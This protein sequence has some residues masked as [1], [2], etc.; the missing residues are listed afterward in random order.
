MSKYVSREVL[1]QMYKLY[2]R[3]YVDYGDLICHKDDP[4]VP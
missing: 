3:F 4:E 2:V 1:D